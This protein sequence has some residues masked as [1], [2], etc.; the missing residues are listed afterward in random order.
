MTGGQ[1]S[2]E[3][4]GHPGAGL[5]RQESAEGHATKTQTEAAEEIPAVHAKINLGTVHDGRG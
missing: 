5:A 1:D 2:G 4:A 3:G